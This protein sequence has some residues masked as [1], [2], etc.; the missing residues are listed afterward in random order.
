MVY[1]EVKTYFQIYKKLQLKKNIKNC[2]WDSWDMIKKIVMY[3][4]AKIHFLIYSTCREGI[5]DKL[6]EGGEK[7]S[8]KTQ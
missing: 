4:R 3:G 2:T 8:M 6:I 1:Y 5:V 7:I